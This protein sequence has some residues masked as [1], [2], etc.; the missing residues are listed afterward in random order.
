MS[1][2]LISIRI[3][4]VCVIDSKSSPVALIF[5]LENSWIFPLLLLLLLMMKIYINK[6]SRG[7][8]IQQ[9]EKVD[10]DKNLFLEQQQ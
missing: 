4:F 9:S 6:E 5:S 7:H 1:S 2:W 10:E 3:I 8:F